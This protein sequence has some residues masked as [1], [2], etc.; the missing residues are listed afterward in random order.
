MPGVPFLVAEVGQMR[1]GDLH[2]VGAMLG[3]RAGAGRSGE[4]AR[5]VEHA[6]ARER[7]IAGW[8]RL[9]RAVAD[10]HDLHQRQR[11][12]GGGLRMPRPFRLRPRHAA[13]ALCGDDRLLEVGGVPGGNGARH[14]I[15]ILRHAEHAERGRAMIGEIAVEIAP[16][17][18]P[19]GIDAH[20]AVARG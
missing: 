12:D 5:K 4:D 9:G 6:D 18:V 3:E 14:R 10:A 11:G 13:G 17:A 20:D 19:G 1:G 8:Q 7:P 2:D 16:A 15:A